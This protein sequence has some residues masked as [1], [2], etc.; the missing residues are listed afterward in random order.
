MNASDTGSKFIKFADD[1]TILTNGASVK[2]SAQKMNAALLKVS[3]WFQRSK[4]NLNP[5]KTRH[6]IFNSKCDGNNSVRIGTEPT[7]CEI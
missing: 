3:I 7:V 6:M 5:S 4:L 2:E 1:T